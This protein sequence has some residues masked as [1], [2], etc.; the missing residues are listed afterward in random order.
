MEPTAGEGASVPKRDEASAEAATIVAV[1][2]AETQQARCATLLSNETALLHQRVD[3]IVAA[4]QVL[5]TTAAEVQATSEGVH[6]GVLAQVVSLCTHLRALFA[7]ID[8]LERL[9][10]AYAAAVDTVEARAA[11]ALGLRISRPPAAAAAAAARRVAGG[12]RHAFVR[13]QVV[14]LHHDI[15]VAP[16]VALIASSI[17]SFPCQC[18]CIS[19]CRPNSP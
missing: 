16:L 8:A 11:S 15:D 9:V 7:Q 1:S 18:H 4:L 6:R 17:S 2:V 12:V 19:N 13:V 3:D 14:L 10:L 5:V